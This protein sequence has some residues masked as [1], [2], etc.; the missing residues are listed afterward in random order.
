[1][2]VVQ[3][4]FWW[5]LVKI[6]SDHISHVRFAYNFLQRRDGAIRMVLW[7]SAVRGALTDMHIA[8]L[9][10]P[11]VDLKVTTPKVG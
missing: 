5:P 6:I 11:P 4:Q 7:W 8:I 2:V 3:V 9:R 1:M 10:S